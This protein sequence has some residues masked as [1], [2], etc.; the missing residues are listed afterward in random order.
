MFKF[1]DKATYFDVIQ[2]PHPEA[3][4]R[5]SGDLKHIQ[6]LV[7]WSLVKD[8]R[9][10]SILEA[11]GGATRMLRALDPSNRMTNADEFLGNDGGPGKV[12][13]APGVVVHR[14]KVGERLL[15]A[16]SF[17]LVFSVSVI[18]HIPSGAPL[19]SF[20]SD[21]YRLLKPGG[22]TVHAID[23]YLH[24]DSNLS[25]DDTVN[26]FLTYSQN[27]VHEYRRLIEGVGLVLDEPPAVD[28][29][30]LLFHSSYATNSDGQM[31]AWE[32]WAPNL[33]AVRRQS[34]SAS[35]IVRAGKPK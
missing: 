19:E 14:H 2:S 18:E 25:N 24:S 30:R 8:Y 10:A 32:K 27:R 6:D 22:K 7:L 4:D 5:W 17:D 28:F 29:D 23:V 16:E 15:P 12:D 35:L 13:D 1:I 11:G 9:A 20:F 3:L 34:Q 31:L 21:I 33:A 26:Q